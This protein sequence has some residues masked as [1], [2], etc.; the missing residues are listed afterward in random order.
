MG[1]FLDVHEEIER[2]NEVRKDR[3]SNVVY[4]YDTDSKI[5]LGEPL[6]WEAAVPQ[7]DAASYGERYAD[8]VRPPP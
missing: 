7:D 5:D 8:Q 3:R 2:I 6:E 4:G 1:V